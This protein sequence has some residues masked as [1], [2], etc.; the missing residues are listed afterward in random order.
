MVSVRFLPLLSVLFFLNSITLQAQVD[1]AVLEM[2]SLQDSSVLS[3]SVYSLNINSF[4][5]PDPNRANLFKDS[6]IAVHTVKNLDFVGW[7]KK[8]VKN[9]Q[10][11]NK[12]APRKKGELWVIAFVFVALIL[13][14]ILRNM[15][16]NE[17]SA[18]INAFFSNRVLGQINK[19][20]KFFNSWPFVFLYLLFGFTIGMFLYQCGKYFQLSYSYS[21]F[22]WFLRLSMIVIGLFTLKIILLRLLGFL[23]DSVKLV[24]EY[25]SI[26][27]LSY[28]S[29]A[30]LF[31]PI[32]VAFSLTPTRFAPY[33]IYLSLALILFIA[34]F[35]F[36]RAVSNILTSYKFPKLYLILYLCALEICPILVLIKALRF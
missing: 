22:Q 5:A 27:F 15:F 6:L 16:F 36:T 19:E 3:D 21:G 23:F 34:F 13:F 11:Y 14:A 32:V 2:H 26:L 30:L 33:Y 25:I 24:K 4:Q 8:F 28:F 20:E 31:L 10:Q 35:Q 7:A 29:A 12:G 17:L 9:E 18:I 1:S